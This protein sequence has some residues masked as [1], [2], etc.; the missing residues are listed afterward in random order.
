MK[1]GCLSLWSIAFFLFLGAAC[2]KNFDFSSA[3]AGGNFSPLTTDNNWTYKFTQ[4]DSFSDTF[5]LT[6]TGKDTSINAKT[7]KVLSYSNGRENN[8]MAKIGSDYY[9][10]TSFPG[11]G[12]EKFEELYLKDNLPV[13]STWTSSIAIAAGSAASDALVANLKMDEGSGTTLT[14]ASDYRNNATTTGD[15]TWVTGV[16]GQALKL[17]GTSQ[18]ATVPDDASLNITSAITLAA[19]I[20]PEKKATQYV[21]KK[22]I[23]GIENGYELSLSADGLVFFRFNQL[24]SAD[25]FRLNSAGSYPIDGKTWMHVAATYDGSVIKIYMN[26]VENSSKTVTSPSPISQNALPLTIGAQGDGSRK[27]AGTVDDVRIYNAALSAS[28]IRSFIYSSGVSD[29]LTANLN[30]VIKE[31]NV[32][33]VVNG[34]TYSNVTHVRL[35][36]TF[37]STVDFGGG[38]FY[39][40][41]D[42]GLIENNISY[43]FPGQPSYKSEQELISYVIK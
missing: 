32:S 1:R 12:S 26:G 4:G 31:R 15:P 38:D 27:L 33:H 43:T 5:T 39:Y 29:T 23:M 36:I 37:N 2:Q 19:W 21:I 3:N 24:S 13:N 7:Y 34:K 22:A 14:D 10:F 18:Y 30:Y 8:Y 40:A 41:Q 25:T 6:A 35:N 9:N 28:D 17:N 11:S 16:T 42:V 20:K